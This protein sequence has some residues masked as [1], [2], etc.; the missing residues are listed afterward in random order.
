LA[1]KKICLRRSSFLP[2][3]VAAWFYIPPYFQEG[4]MAT[5]EPN[6][7]HLAASL[8]NINKTRPAAADKIY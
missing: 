5:R 3:R 2:P 7:P 8:P 4:K 1:A 6:T